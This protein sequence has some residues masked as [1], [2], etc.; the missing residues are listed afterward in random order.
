MRRSTND[1]ADPNT[2][3]SLLI[4]AALLFACWLWAIWQ[5]DQAARFM[6]EWSYV[7]LLGSLT[8]VLMALGL[9]LH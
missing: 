5:R 1:S 3:T 7:P 2:M 8:C 4:L 9:W 6:Q